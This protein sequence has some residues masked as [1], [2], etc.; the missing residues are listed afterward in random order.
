MRDHK[1]AKRYRKVSILHVLTFT[2]LQTRIRHG[3]QVDCLPRFTDIDLVGLFWALACMTLTISASA[4]TERQRRKKQLTLLNQQLSMKITA[5]AVAALTGVSSVSASAFSLR[6]VARNLMGSSSESP[7]APA[8]V[9]VI[10]HGLLHETSLDDMKII[11]KSIVAAYNHAYKPAGHSLDAFDPHTFVEF[12]RGEQDPPICELCPD[13]DVAGIDSQS[14]LV[15]ARVGA[16]GEQDPPICEL[17]PDDDLLGM[18]LGGTHQ[19]FQETFCAVIRS[20]GSANLAKVHDCS[21]SFLEMTGGNTDSVPIRSAVKQFC[22][23]DMKMEAQVMVHGA[24][25]DFTK[26]DLALINK[27]AK[28]AYNDAFSSTG[29]AIGSFETVREMDVPGVSQDPPICELC[30]DDDKAFAAGGVTKLL[31][32]RVAPLCPSDDNGSTVTD[33][34]KLLFMHEAFEKAFCSKLQNSGTANFANVQDCTFRMVSSPFTSAKTTQ[35]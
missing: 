7:S 17:C 15:L 33:D 12:N 28:S 35:K 24:L 22:N 34:V 29:F 10:L 30:P 20:S 5:F 3:T 19:K 32:T 23:N 14:Q 16:K 27:S 1:S 31:V 21:F 6:S 18:E 9:R 13:D 11:S 8:D 26:E 25:H 4:Q 2:T